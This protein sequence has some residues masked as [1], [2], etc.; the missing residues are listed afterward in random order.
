MEPAPA[1]F[2]P[3]SLVGTAAQP[4]NSN[5]HTNNRKPVGLCDMVSKG[6]P[7]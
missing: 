5:A 1:L 6:N 4:A 2:V 7:C 3:V